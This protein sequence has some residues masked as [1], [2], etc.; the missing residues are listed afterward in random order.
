MHENDA[1]EAIVVALDGRAPLRGALRPV[2]DKSISHRALMFA[3]IGEGASRIRGAN[4]GADVR[5]TA[6]CLR[7]LGVTVREVDDEHFEV[8]G[9]GLRLRPATAALDCGNSGTTMRLLA[10]ILAGQP[11][12]STL[13]G[14]TSLRTRPMA[15]IA[16]P[17][18]AI[19]A[20]VEGP[21][22]GER[23][24]L[25]ITGGTLHRQHFELDIASAQVKSCLLLAGWVGAVEIEVREPGASRDH[26]ERMMAER[27]VAIEFGP[28]FARLR[29]GPAWSAR[30]V[31]VPAD[32]SAA[33]LLAAAV[34][35]VP[36][37]AVQ[38]R[39]V[40]TNP[41][42]TAFV[43][44][45]ER[46]GAGVR[47]SE[48]AQ[49]GGEE[50]ATLTVE[51]VDTL[52]STIVEGDEVPQLIDEV[53]ALAVLAGF[54]HGTTIFEGVGEL[55]V[56][57]SDRIAATQELLRQFGVR[58]ESGPARL[59]VHGGALRRPDRVVPAS[60]DHR[61]AMASAVLA[62]A[63]SARDGGG[64]IDVDLTAAAVSDPG[65]AGRIEHLQR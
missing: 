33:A 57:E 21:T 25:V 37:S 35:A 53:P 34:L 43:P 47:W 5:S 60:D 26:T 20:R 55:R 38:L 12:T 40:M 7:A 4:P 32:P 52:R 14:D 17:L 49:A 23:P 10:G 15:R 56:K 18:R 39:F 62:L 48:R 50:V 1:G 28:G 46:M 9:R 51:A 30:D 64:P 2:G 27:G 3:A 44:V 59:V 63:T 65:F 24:P 61:L 19:G 11:F 16:K 41:T 6:G 8:I 54:A 36:G 13:D 58:T 31:D 42:R 29:P 22:N 45:L